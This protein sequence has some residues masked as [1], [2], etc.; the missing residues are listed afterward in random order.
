MVLLSYLLTHKK[1]MAK[2]I[3]ISEKTST[4]LDALAKKGYAKATL[5]G[6][7]VEEFAQKEGFRDTSK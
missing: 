2:N 7:L 6:R 5:V 4:L 3:G 1:N